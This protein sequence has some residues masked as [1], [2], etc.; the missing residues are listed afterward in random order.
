[1]VGLW[2]GGSEPHPRSANTVEAGETGTLSQP[3]QDATRQPYVTYSSSP[4]CPAGTLSVGLEQLQG[5]RRLLCPD[6]AGGW[7]MRVLLSR[8]LRA[9]LPRLGR[10]PASP[11]CR[12]HTGSHMFQGKKEGLS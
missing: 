8:W 3:G 10:A 12:A 5:P 6:W 4:P 2:W 7:A 1:M 9:Q 11:A